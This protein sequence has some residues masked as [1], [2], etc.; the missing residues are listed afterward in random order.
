MC[1]TIHFLFLP[2]TNTYFLFVAFRKK[3]G[4]EDINKTEST[5]YFFESILKLKS[6]LSIYDR[7]RVSH[8]EFLHIKHL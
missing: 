8:H 3:V 2:I 6:K 5:R 4:T 1:V 7:K